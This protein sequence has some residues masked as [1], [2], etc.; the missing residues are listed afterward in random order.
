MKFAC[1]RSGSRE[2][3]RKPVRLRSLRS[4]VSGSMWSHTDW[5]A[6]SETS[7]TRS[8]LKSHQ[9]ITIGALSASWRSISR[10]KNRP[11]ELLQGDGV[12]DEPLRWTGGEVLQR[13]DTSG[14]MQ[15]GLGLRTGNKS[16]GR[17]Q[18]VDGGREKAESPSH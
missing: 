16:S 14:S 9:S 17:N 8:G 13:V 6:R 4:S 7:A 1:I 3:A 18:V 11:H 10:L 15:V 12:G 2:P 5:I